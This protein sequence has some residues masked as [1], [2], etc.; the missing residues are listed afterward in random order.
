MIKWYGT[1]IGYGAS[2]LGIQNFKFFLFY[3]RDIDLYSEDKT[4][5]KKRQI[6]PEIAHCVERKALLATI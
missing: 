6:M 4:E 1:N 5:T 3:K 2:I